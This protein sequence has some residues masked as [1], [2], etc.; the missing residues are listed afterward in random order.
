MDVSST[1]VYLLQIADSFEVPDGSGWS[2]SLKV[3]CWMN[4]R[5]ALVYIR[6]A[7]LIVNY[8]AA[9]ITVLCVCMNVLLCSHY[10]FNFF[11]T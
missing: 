4:S 6:T 1:L 8:R 2:T 9:N 7:V 5:T 11:F 3:Y 10:K